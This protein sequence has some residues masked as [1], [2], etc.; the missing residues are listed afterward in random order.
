MNKRQ[1]LQTLA[2]KRQRARWP[3]YKGIGDYHHG[4][5]ECPYVSPYTKTAGN[6]DA[7]IMVIL[8]DWS[9][10]K[11][12]RGPLDSD[13]I[14]YGYTRSL[15]T[16]QNLVSLLET[17]FGVSLKDVYGTNLFPFIKMGHMGTNI[18]RHDL[19]RA[20]HEFA[21]PQ[22]TIVRPKLVICL[23]HVTFNALREASGFEPVYPIAKAIQNPFNLAQTRIWCQAHTGVR[24]QN[25]RNSGRKR[26]PNDWKQMKKDVSFKTPAMQLL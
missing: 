22:I 12:L 23:G 6:I 3:G 18:P 8:Q 4:A 11:S 24:G 16:N 2:T 19:V 5:Y 25:N 10:D 1:R 13:S 7:E 17:H 9:S 21:L 14:T 15:P 26:V 20:A